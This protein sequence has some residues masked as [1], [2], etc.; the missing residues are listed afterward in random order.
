MT[1]TTTLT[2]WCRWRCYKVNIVSITRIYL[3]M[4]RSDNLLSCLSELFT[5]RGENHQCTGDPLLCM[6]TIH[7]IGDSPVTT[8]P[9]S[10]LKNS[11]ISW[12]VLLDR[13]AGQACVTSLQTGVKYYKRGWNIASRGAYQEMVFWSPMK[14]EVR[15]Y[16]ARTETRI[17]YSRYLG[18]K[19]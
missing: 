19:L 1:L 11:H 9:S 14:R 10:E 2:L 12:T 18:A 15:K 6:W 3:I 4:K 16:W 7:C 5:C 17:L 8:L 13:Q